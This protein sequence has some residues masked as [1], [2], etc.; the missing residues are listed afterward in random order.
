M[1]LGGLCLSRLW[2]TKPVER[3]VDLVEPTAVE[4][5][6]STGIIAQHAAVFSLNGDQLTAD[7]ENHKWSATK[8][9]A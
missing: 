4:I 2:P 6:D 3:S 7:F 8:L 5:P 1:R 9:T